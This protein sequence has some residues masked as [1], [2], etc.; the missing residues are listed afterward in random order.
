[1]VD[2]YDDGRK[3]T[4]NND[5]TPLN[6]KEIPKNPVAVALE[7]TEDGRDLP[8]ITAAGRGKVAEQILQLAF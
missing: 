3:K 7:E 1:M 4:G 2:Q 8:R 6:S 5:L